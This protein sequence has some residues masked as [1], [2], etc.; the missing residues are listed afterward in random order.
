MNIISYFPLINPTPKTINPNNKKPPIRTPQ[1]YIYR[2]LQIF[3]L[4]VPYLINPD[5]FEHQ[6]ITSHKQAITA[7][8]WIYFFLSFTAKRANFYFTFFLLIQSSK[9]FD[10]KL[11]TYLL[12]PQLFTNRL[13]CQILPSLL[14]VKDSLNCLQNN[15]CTP[16]RP[17]VHLYIKAKCILSE[18][19]I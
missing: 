8:I 17:G 5:F 13:F 15:K 7:F 6:T 16:V 1:L 11:E 4:I 19:D 3:N 14:S 12:S 2:H 9:A 10:H 18:T